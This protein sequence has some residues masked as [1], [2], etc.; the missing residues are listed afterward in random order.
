MP[1]IEYNGNVFASYHDADTVLDVLEAYERGDATQRELA[2]AHGLSSETVRRWVTLAGLTKSRVEALRL[3]WDRENGTSP[4]HRR[5]ARALYL[6]RAMP[7]EAIASV[8]D[9]NASA[10][11]R[12]VA[13][14]AR[15]ISEARRAVFH[16]PR[17]P[18]ARA[19]LQRIRAVCR[20]VVV[21]ELSQTEAAATFDLARSTVAKYLKSEHNPYAAP[22]GRRAA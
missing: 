17:H 12:W 3:R 10:V 9:V 20:A 6:E 14:V 8:L 15:S 22:P 19:R 7:P 11:R 1:E 2:R 16:D 4:E 13:P 5:R 21:D 18:H